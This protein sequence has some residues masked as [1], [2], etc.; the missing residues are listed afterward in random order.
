MLLQFTKNDR[1]IAVA[2][3]KQFNSGEKTWLND[4]IT[5]GGIF[6]LLKF[7]YLSWVPSLITQH[8]SHVRIALFDQFIVVD[9]PQF[10][11]QHIYLR[12]L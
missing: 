3:K 2:H 4:F 6:W 9:T 8:S 12:A 1:S 7:K 5:R 11:V 10:V